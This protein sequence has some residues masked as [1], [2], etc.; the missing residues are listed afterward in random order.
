MMHF[1]NDILIVTGTG[2]SMLSSK[3]GINI[4]KGLLKYLLMTTSRCFD[5]LYLRGIF[6]VYEKGVA[7]VG[8]S[9]DLWLH[10]LFYI[11]EIVQHQDNAA[12][13]LRA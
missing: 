2:E 10:Y 9:V 1:S 11:Q 12:E 8:L 5:I 13:K 6:Q 4:T 3:E 7:A